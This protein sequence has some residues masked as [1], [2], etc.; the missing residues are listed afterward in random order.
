MIVNLLVMPI[1]WP[2][3]RRMVWGDWSW[4]RQEDILGAMDARH[5]R[6]RGIVGLS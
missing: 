5:P 2:I 1:V 3:Q 6:A 4:I